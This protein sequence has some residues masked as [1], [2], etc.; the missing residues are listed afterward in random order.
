M[1]TLQ[2][3]EWLLAVKWKQAGRSLDVLIQYCFYCW[4][5][6]Y[7]SQNEIWS[8]WCPLRLLK[9]YFC[10]FVSKASI[11]LNHDPKLLCT[12]IKVNSILG[13]WEVKRLN[14]AYRPVQSWVH[15]NASGALQAFSGHYADPGVHGAVV[16]F[17]QRDK[18]LHIEKGQTLCIHLV[19][20]L[21][22]HH[23]DKESDSA[24]CQPGVGHTI[25]PF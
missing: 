20:H 4:S 3:F 14:H 6:C 1:N 25:I 24:G 18:V 2:P 8:F 13:L 9:F 5:S 19:P 23:P 21:L 16:S 15:L 17:E 7:F 10:P 12:S 22:T 11:Y